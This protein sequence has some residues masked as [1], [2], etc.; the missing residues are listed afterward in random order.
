[1]IWSKMSLLSKRPPWHVV[2]RATNKIGH[3]G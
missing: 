2:F 1:V 3:H